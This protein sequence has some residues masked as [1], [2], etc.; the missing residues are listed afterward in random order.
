LPAS[1]AAFEREAVPAI[2][3]LNTRGA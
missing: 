1:M 2:E 3:A